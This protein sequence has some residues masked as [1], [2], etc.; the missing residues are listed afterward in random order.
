M[1]YTKCIHLT[2]HCRLHLKIYGDKKNLYVYNKYLYVHGFFQNRWEIKINF[3]EHI[4]LIKILKRHSKLQS[5]GG[6]DD[7][8]STICT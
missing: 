6:S 7:L 2:F 3:Q 1:V 5:Y 8:K 4:N